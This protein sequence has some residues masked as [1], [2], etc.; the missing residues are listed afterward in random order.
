MS[1]FDY[2]NARLRA[3]ISRLLTK[4][5]LENL[6][7][8]GTITGLISALTKTAYHKSV[9]FALAR[10][11]GIDC[12]NEALRMD[13]INTLCKLRGFY[14]ERAGVM[15][16]IILRFYDLHNITAILRGLNNN[17]VPVKIFAT[18]VPVGDLDLHT[19]TALSRAAGLR[20][21]IDM[22]ASMRL[23]FAPPL[24]RLR[25]EQLST[26]IPQMELALQRWHFQ[27][28]QDYA[29]GIPDAKLFMAA[30]NLDADLTNLRTIL[31]F[32]HA[33]NE[34]EAIY[35]QTSPHHIQNLFIGPGN[36]PFSLL[37]LCSQQENIKQALELL[38]STAYG[39]VLRTGLGEYR[40]SGHLSDI[41]RQLN[42]FRLNWMASKINQNPLGIGLVLGYITLKVNEV[43]NLRW[44]TNGIN[45]SLKLEEIRGRL[46]II[47]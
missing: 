12:I 17:I 37:D 22:M 20:E 42:R 3:M 7:G 10:M 11:T 24:L 41:E 47:V 39:P 19:L 36:I 21:A 16:S 40:A 4:R 35:E 33:P 8:S 15:V 1:A 13:L 34:R 26:S 28:A 5:D 45:L 32:L 27:Q 29:T 30:I 31:R 6:A 44:I 2:G 18:L 38:S 9:E 46:E 23:P 25:S 43:S 14:S